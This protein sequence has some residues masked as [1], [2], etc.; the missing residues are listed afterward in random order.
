M[1]IPTMYFS[2][3]A[4]VLP[5]TA[6]DNDEVLARVR[7]SYSGP[8]EDWT[9]IE[10]TIRY[11]FDRCNTKTRYLDQ[12]TTLSPGDFAAQAASAVLAANG[13]A[14]TDLDLVV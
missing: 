7:E 9:A 2:K 11:V 6:L 4:T 8:A 13:V 10:Q 3:P 12:S 14:A 5:D 1:N